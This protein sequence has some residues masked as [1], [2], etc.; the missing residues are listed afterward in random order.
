M[1]P[2][3][4]VQKYI[5]PWWT[6]DRSESIVRGRLLWTW[7][8]HPVIVMDASDCVDLDWDVA[9]DRVMTVTLCADG[10]VGYSAIVWR[11]ASWDSGLDGG[12]LDEIVRLL[13]ELFPD[14]PQTCGEGV[15]SEQ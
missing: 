10:S 14:G 15:A 1:Y 4:C 8:P 6:E 2:D 13:G 9:K 12:D 3:D 11:V 7:V 5:D